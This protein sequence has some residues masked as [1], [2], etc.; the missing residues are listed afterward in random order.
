VGR[1]VRDRILAD[2]N[3]SQD[4]KDAWARVGAGDVYASY[5]IDGHGSGGSQTSFKLFSSAGGR[6]VRMGSAD[7]SLR[8]ARE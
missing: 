5:D 2:P 4:V 1:A 8:Y 7:A 6:L 3:V